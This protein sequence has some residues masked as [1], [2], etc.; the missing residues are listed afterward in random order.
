MEKRGS[1]LLSKGETLIIEDQT[2]VT[3]SQIDWKTLWTGQANHIY[4]VIRL[5]SIS[6]NF[7]CMQFS[8]PQISVQPK[9]RSISV[10]V[11]QSIYSPP[12]GGKQVFIKLENNQNCLICLIVWKKI[13][14]QGPFYDGKN[15]S[16]YR[17]GS[18]PKV[19]ANSGFGIRPKP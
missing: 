12:L 17:L 6:I 14:F 9:P 10:S 19:L 15:N 4:K 5:Q 13:W 7:S 1:L 8:I 2:L 3:C 16:C 18:H 11:L